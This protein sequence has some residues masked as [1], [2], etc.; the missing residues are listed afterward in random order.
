MAYYS[1]GMNS[2]R[3]DMDRALNKES[4]RRLYLDRAQLELRLRDASSTMED[5][6]TAR[7]L[8]E[9]DDPETLQLESKVY[10]AYEQYD[11]ALIK[12]AKAAKVSD[13]PLVK[14]ALE[15]RSQR[16]ENHRLPTVS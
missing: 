10:F 9:T 5:A 6:A 14:K 8:F 15:H 7:R 12:L 16:N 3:S 11:G 2:T 4:L 13:D 1:R